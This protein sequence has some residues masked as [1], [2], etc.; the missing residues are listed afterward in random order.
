M[1]QNKKTPKR[2]I[3]MTRNQEEKRVEA[4]GVAMSQDTRRVRSPEVEEMADP[5]SNRV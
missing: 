2:K 3:P 1:R 5:H 4:M